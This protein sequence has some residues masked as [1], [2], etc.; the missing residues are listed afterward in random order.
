MEKFKKLRVWNLAMGTLHLIQAVLM[1]LISNDFKLPI[2]TNYLKLSDAAFTLEPVRN[3]I[4]EVRVA[5]LV[6][7]FLLFSAIAHFTISTPGVYKWYVENLKKGI[8]YIRWWEYA[9][10]SSL[11]IVVIGMLVGIYDLNALILMFGL[12]AMMIFFGL[13][14]EI[15]NQTTKKTN[16]I[17]YYFGCIAGAIPWVA[18]ALNLFG[19]GEGDAKP[20][21]FV[22]WIFFSIFIFFNTFAINMILQYKKVGK[23]KDYA[24]G[25]K[26]YI[27]LSLFAKSA[28]AWQ[29]WGGTMRPE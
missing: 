23:W 6:A 25:E 14:M 7:L 10:S 12:N 20:P 15:H 17:S 26:V 22:Y 19:S 8:N 16:W 5:P 2:D 1:F 27:L 29:V 9:F 21:D 3:T 4:L 11:M 28:L 18:I 13:V 24:F